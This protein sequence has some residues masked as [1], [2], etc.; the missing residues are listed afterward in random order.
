M[1]KQDRLCVRGCGWARMLDPQLHGSWQHLWICVSH[2]LL[3]QAQQLLH[4]HI[5][6]LCDLRRCFPLCCDCVADLEAMCGLCAILGPAWLHYRYLQA[7]PGRNGCLCPQR[8]F[9]QTNECIQ[10]IFPEAQRRMLPH[11]G[12]QRFVRASDFVAAERAS[13]GFA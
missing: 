3:V 9:V 6:R 12:L 13:L 11:D 8:V 2:S 1:V 10:A 5:V 4:G 7:H